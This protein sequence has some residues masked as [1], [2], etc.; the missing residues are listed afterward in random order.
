[1]SPSAERAGARYTFGQAQ[2]AERIE[3]AVRGALA[4]GLRTGD[5]APK[6]T[7]TATTTEMG[8]AVLKHL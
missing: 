4:T 6:N 2:V 5:I 8:S 1:M 3:K 7:K